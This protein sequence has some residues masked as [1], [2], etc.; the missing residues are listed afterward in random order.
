[1]SLFY[2]KKDLNIFISSSKVGDASESIPVKNKLSDY[3]YFIGSPW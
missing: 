1:M 2:E 3:S